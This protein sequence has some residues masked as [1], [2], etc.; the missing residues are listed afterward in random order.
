VVEEQ[1]LYDYT[2]HYDAGGTEFFTPARIPAAAAEAAEA[3]AKAAL[4][5]HEALGLRH[6]PRTDLI[7][8][9][10]GTVHFLEV[11][12]LEVN[13]FLEANV[14]PGM[15]ATS[16]PPA[17]QAADLD[18]GLLCRDLLLRCFL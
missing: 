7:V 6:L 17:V 11:N 18:L 13:V 1:G 2:A 9:R 12:F 15:T 10:A 8:D 16:L 5:A 4:T 14:A 3:A